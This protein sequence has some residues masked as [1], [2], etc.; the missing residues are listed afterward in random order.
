MTDPNPQTDP[1]A[2]CMWRE[3]CGEGQDGMRAVGHVIRNRGEQ[4]YSHLV[5]PFHFAVY[6][7]GQFTSMSDPSD[8][9]YRR[10]PA[11]V[12][13]QWQFAVIVTPKILDGSDAD[14]TEGA[15][16]YARL[17]QISTSGWFY[18][19][20]VEKSKAHPLL[21]IIGHHSFYA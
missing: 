12:D 19:N 18:L 21:A 6:A 16:Y 17:D 1:V 5:D 13:P 4:W 3:A 20:I 2:L 7:K 8:P 11:D 15:L 10:F 14:L 9:N